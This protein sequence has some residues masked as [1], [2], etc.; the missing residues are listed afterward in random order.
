VFL[1]GLM[2]CCITVSGQI[3]LPRLISDGIVLQRDSKLNIWGWA[4]PGESVNLTFNGNTLATLADDKGNWK[5]VLP[6]QA[7][8][9]PFEMTLK[10]KNEIVVHNILIGD[11]WICSGQSNMEQVFSRLKDK[12]PQVIANSANTNI[13][14]FIVPTRYAFDGPQQDIPGGTWESASPETMVRFT[15]VGYFFAKDLYDKY[16]VPIGLIRSA[17]GGTPAE[18]W[19]SQEAVKSFPQHEAVAKKFSNTSY[20][21]SLRTAEGTSNKAWYNAI[22]KED[23]GLN[24]TP[25]WYETQYDASSWSVMNVPGYWSEQGLP[26][27]NGVVWFRKEVELPSSF[28]SRPVRLQLGNVVDCDSVYVNGVFSGTT[29]YQY[30]PRKYDLPAGVF[31]AGKNVIVVRVINTTGKGGFYKGK[32]YILKAENDTIN[33]AG[34]WKYQVG[35]KQEALQPGTFYNGKPTGLFNAMIAPLL[36]TSIKG[37]IWY[38]GESNAS[39][40]AEYKTLFPAMITNWREKW[41]Q[42]NFPFLYVQL[43]NYLPAKDQPS[44]SEWAELREAQLQTLKLPNT[45]MAVAIDVGEW[46]DIHPLN[47]EDVGKRLA[48]AAEKLAYQDKKVVYSGPLYR[49]IKIKGNHIVV[50]FDHVGGGLTAKGGKDLKYF[51][52]AGAD[53]KFV[54]ASAKIVGNTVVVWSDAIKQPV[55]V[56]YAWADN[57]E[58]ANLYNKEGLPASPFR[59]DNFDTTKK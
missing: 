10:G 20:T 15:A 41:K 27:V 51:S 54:W 17:A 44:E 4:S 6:A 9:G 8:G 29:G 26:G 37:V 1:A 3:K 25:R 32:P 14:Q 49:S 13:R 45:A 43:A 31:K 40:A 30:P 34:E 5:I 39:R 52:I 11:V 59:T 28:E 53:K 47:K 55:A 58:G 48:L 2:V 7:A 18:A 46:N 19:I 35:V 36:Q 57:P 38:Q 33:L 21:D 56:R 16:K 12:Y 50:S 24:E 22:R 23:K 42:G